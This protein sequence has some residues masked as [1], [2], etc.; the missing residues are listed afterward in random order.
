MKF[1]CDK[2]DLMK[3]LTNLSKAIAVKPQTP[4]LGGI[5]LKVQDGE[6]EL[7]TNNYSL[8]MKAKIKVNAQSEG[9]VVP[10]GKKFVDAVKVMPGDAILVEE[11][12]DE[13]CVLVASGRAKFKIPLFHVEEFP[14]VTIKDA[15]I[16]KISINPLVLK[17]LINQ[18][19]FSCTKEE[20]HPIYTG[21]LFDT[22]GD[23]LTVVGT[24]MHRLSIAQDRMQEEIEKKL[25]F[26]IP[27]EALRAIAEMLPDDDDKI[28]QVDINCT[29]KDVSFMIDNIFVK[30]RIIDGVFPEYNKV[31]PKGSETIVHVNVEEI[32]AA[33]DRISLISKDT[34][35]KK[36]TFDFSDEGLKISAESPDSGSA[37]EVLD[38]DMEGPALKISFNYVYI[39]DLLRTLKSDTCQISMKGQY[40]PVDIREDG[41][42]DEYVY[43]VT[44]VRG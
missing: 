43:V 28:D 37:E 13:G 40:D 25:R 34:A 11:I 41:K 2:R 7:Q 9:E 8:G 12:E 42:S 44:P 35:N 20:T 10:L 16:T 14:K 17:S 26:V 33:M 5:Y 24:N 21:C 19:V 15:E 39:V 18:T 4:A 6:L 23:I 27:A 31:I 32:S 30:A 3:V 38:V 1:T 29:E 36:V 22:N